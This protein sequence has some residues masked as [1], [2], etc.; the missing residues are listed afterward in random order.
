MKRL[1]A[2]RDISP[3]YVFSR[4]S[5]CRW[6]DG[7]PRPAEFCLEA[8]RAHSRV[9]PADTGARLAPLRTVR[10]VRLILPEMNGVSI[11]SAVRMSPKN[12]DNVDGL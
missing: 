11:R 3:T 12:A 1:A 6:I 4:A 9:L 8:C 2:Y 5:I 10:R 7:M